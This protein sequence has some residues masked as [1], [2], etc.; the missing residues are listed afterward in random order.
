MFRVIC[1]FDNSDNFGENPQN[2]KNRFRLF[3][4][5]LYV[6]EMYHFE[7]DIRKFTTPG[8]CNGFVLHC[9]TQHLR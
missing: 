2:E 6:H 8:I 7:D 3:D 4:F 5:K 9:L 1:M